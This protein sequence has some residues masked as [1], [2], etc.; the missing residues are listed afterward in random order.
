M[1]IK[2][3]MFEASDCYLVLFYLAFF[4]QDVVKVRSELISVFHVDT[5][6]RLLLEGVVPYLTL[7]MKSRRKEAA[8]ALSKKTDEVTND[9]TNISTL[10]ENARKDHY[11]QFDDYIEMIIQLGYIVSDVFGDTLLMAFCIIAKKDAHELISFIFLQTLFASAYPLAPFV[12]IIANFIELRLDAFKLTYVTMRPRPMPSSDVGTWKV[13]IK[14]IVWMSAITNCFIFCFS[15]MQMYQYLPE[16][17]TVDKYGEHDLKAGSGIVVIFL[18]FGIERLLIV[19]G[20]LIDLFVPDLPEAIVKK[21]KRKQFVDF[22]LHQEEK[23]KKKKEWETKI[24]ALFS[25]EKFQSNNT[26][27]GPK[28]FCR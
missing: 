11:E 6:R 19:L 26:L 8:V 27:L 28:N 20:L 4:E 5:F 7:K 9:E 3:F 1:I 18:L 12:A 25:P 21:E 17:F 22:R 14:I 13:L 2:R 15:S 16:Y 23:A 10:A 24:K